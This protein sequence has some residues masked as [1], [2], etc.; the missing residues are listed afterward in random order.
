MSEFYAAPPKVFPGDKVLVQ[1][2]RFKNE[3]WEY[4]V[5]VDVTS[6]IYRKAENIFTLRY[7]YSVCIE[8]KTAKLGSYLLYVSGDQIE[9]IQAVEEA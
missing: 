8:R 9:P 2:T 6:G 5:V 7:S 4:G 3:V 1:N